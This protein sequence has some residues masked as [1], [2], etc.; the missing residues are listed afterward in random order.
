MSAKQASKSIRRRPEFDYNDHPR[1]EKLVFICGLHR[2]GTTLLEQLLVSQLDLSCLRMDVPENE[3]QHAQSVYSPA[4]LFGGFGRFAFSAEMQDELM[5]LRD[6]EQCRKTIISDWARFIVGS[7]VTLIE[8]SPPNLT[9]I[10]WLRKVFPGARFLILVRDPRAVAGATC[11][12]SGTSLEEL[13]MHWNVAYSMA[14]RDISSED[15]MTVK[16]EDLAEC[17]SAAVLRIAGF[18]GVERRPHALPMAERHRE[19][20]SSNKKYIAMHGCRF[21][22]KGAWNDFGY[23]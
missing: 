7:S 4:R 16:Y 12:F 13:M 3:G 11:K 17:A 8:K 2:S 5:S 22:G 23:C 19:I 6:L 14:L 21:Y 20:V 15:C 9:K 18:L 1:I 10:W